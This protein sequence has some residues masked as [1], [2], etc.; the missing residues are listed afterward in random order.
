MSFRAVNKCRRIK[1]VRLD[2]VSGM[3]AG[4][5]RIDPLRQAER[6]YRI[7]PNYLP[8]GEHCRVRLLAARRSTR[9]TLFS[10]TG[11]DVAVCGL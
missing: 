2:E 11:K 5:P 9:A 4:S 10:G 1:I 6:N 8:P 7:E 3:I